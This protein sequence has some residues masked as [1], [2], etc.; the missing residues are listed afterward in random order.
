VA[1]ISVVEE[2]LSGTFDT[3]TATRTRRSPI[4]DGEAHAQQDRL[5][6]APEP[7]PI[8]APSTWSET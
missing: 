3:N 1:R 7:K 6:R 8:A 2:R 4:T 5:G